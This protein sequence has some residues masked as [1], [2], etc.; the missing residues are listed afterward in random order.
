MNI[1][2]CRDTSWSIAFEPE[3]GLI[4]F[5]CESMR[6][7]KLLRFVLSYEVQL[8]FVDSN[9]YFMLLEAGFDEIKSVCV[10][11]FAAPRHPSSSIR[12]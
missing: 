2:L 5:Y 9:Y 3:L 1:I 4:R 12:S 11:G 7:V 10:S 8:V 6:R